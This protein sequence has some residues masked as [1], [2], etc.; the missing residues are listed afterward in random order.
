M[1]MLSN[2]H[3][4]LML[5]AHI[6]NYRFIKCS[7]L[8]LLAYTV[9]YNFSYVYAMLTVIAHTVNTYFLQQLSA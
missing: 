7:V 6:V 8:E 3:E 2:K 5:V 9:N 4:V 1:L